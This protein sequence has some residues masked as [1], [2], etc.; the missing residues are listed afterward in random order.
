MDLEEIKNIIHNINKHV[1]YKIILFYF[2]KFKYLKFKISKSQKFHKMKTK[3]NFI[4][5]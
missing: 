4:F 5:F 2:F 3:I 1:I